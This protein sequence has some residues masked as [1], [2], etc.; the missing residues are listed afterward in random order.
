MNDGRVLT[1]QEMRQY[2]RFCDLSRR[3]LTALPTE[4]AQLTNLKQLRLSGNQL[5]ALPAEIAQLTNLQTLWLSRNQLTALP[6]E[7]GQL[8]NL[9]TADG[10]TATS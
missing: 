7:I 10:S 3:G 1:A 6:P 2:E 4:I 9:Q 5:T 8:T